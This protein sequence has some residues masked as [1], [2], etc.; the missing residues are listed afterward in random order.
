MNEKPI[1]FNGD[2]VQ[3]ILD[4]RKT[5]TRRVIKP[6]PQR[7]LLGDWSYFKSKRSLF[8]TQTWMSEAV[9]LKYLAGYCPYGQP[10]D[11]LWVRE[12]W[13][14]PGNYDHIKPSK[15]SDTCFTQDELAYRATETHGDVYYKWRPSIFMP[16]WASRIALRVTGVRAERVQEI[17]EEDA[18]AEGA[19]LWYPKDECLRSLL[20]RDGSYRN[21]FHELWDRIN[22]RRGFPWSANPWVWVV[23]FEREVER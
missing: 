21:G 1:L 7:G 14:T 10:G 22:T 2:M 6:Q 11:T 23:E 4:G 9:M 5:Q 19:N 20:R 8:A 18:R 17:S 12:T 3:A 16:R 15:L 13:A